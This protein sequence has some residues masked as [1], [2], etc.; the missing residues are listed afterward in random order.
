MD[1]WGFGIIKIIVLNSTTTSVCYNFRL[2]NF[3]V[4]KLGETKEGAHAHKMGLYPGGL[5]RE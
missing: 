4:C 5:H 3:D 2:K 1:I